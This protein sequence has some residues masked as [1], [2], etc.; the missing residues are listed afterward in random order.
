MALT[1]EETPVLLNPTLSQADEEADLSRR[2]DTPLKVVI[3]SSFMLRLAGGATALLLSAYL[4]QIVHADAT[5]IGLLYA[6]FYVS[7]L[8]LSP[9]FGA[10]SD[11]RGRRFLLVLGPLVGAIALPFYPLTTTILM[12]IFARLLEGVSTAAKV[13][14]ALG[15]LADATAGP[16]KKIAAL[17][18]RVMGIYEISF[19]VGIV[20]GSVLGAGLDRFVGFGGFYVISLIYLATAALL[21]FMVPESL[22]EA[23]RLHQQEIREA[24]KGESHPIRTMLSTRA[25][26]YAGLLK[27]PTLLSFMP[28]WLAVNAVV[29]LWSAH[30]Q[31]LMI[32]APGDPVSS[33]LLESN[34]TTG[35]VGVG[36]AVFGI[37]FILGIYLWSRVYAKLRKTNMMIASLVGLFITCVGLL[38][39]NNSW[40]PFGQPIGQWPVAPVVVIGLLLVSG[41]TPVALAFLA[42]ISEAHIAHRGA[43]MGL[44]SVL[45][46]LGQLI[47]AFG[48]GIF[49]QQV[50]L[51]FNGLILG[52]FLLGVVAWVTV[53]RLRTKYGI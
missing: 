32:M 41:F 4:K 27:E 49:I 47:G 24:S 5:L 37:L 29:G 12:L 39:I 22:P 17:R 16:G 38:A 15:Y 23:A 3:I 14:S 53:L 26:S 35:Q 9:I 13:P 10:L 48:G 34:F 21:F 33:Q 51:G 42:E 25:K 8:G 19:L 40:L 30:I 36:A 28:A 2:I 52:S 44:Y 46:G 31:P 18:G 1:T 20:G 7:E 45:L 43:V 11:L 50:G 6:I